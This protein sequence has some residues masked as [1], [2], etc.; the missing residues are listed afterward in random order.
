M[1]R[2]PPLSPGEV[3]HMLPCRTVAQRHVHEPVRSGPS[4]SVVSSA[5]RRAL[6]AT[7]I[8]SGHNLQFGERRAFTKASDGWSGEAT[9]NQSLEDSKQMATILEPGWIW[10]EGDDWR[11]DWV[12]KWSN[13]GVD[14]EGFVYTDSDWQSPSPYPYGH[15]GFARYP[16][17]TAKLPNFNMSSLLN[18]ASNESDDGISVFEDEEDDD[19]E[20]AQFD[21]LTGME[22]RSAKAET[23]RRRWLRRAIWIGKEENE[24]R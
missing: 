13:G 1:L 23:R 24:K 15:Q 18:G 20:A 17:A 21:S 3:L 19:D 2:F 12:G 14:A 9:S 7:G 10:I 4:N 5:I 8:W 16:P 6:G 11:I 22:I